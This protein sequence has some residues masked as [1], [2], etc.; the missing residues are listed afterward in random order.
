[1]QQYQ[2][3]R[4]FID[5]FIAHIDEQRESELQSILLKLFPADIAEL[6]NEL[7]TAQA[8]YVMHIL[9]SVKKVEVLAELEPDVRKDLLRGF[10][11]FEI[12]RE[13]IE[14]M[15]SDDAADILSEFSATEVNE[16]I[17]HIQDKEYSLNLSSLLKYPEDSA[18]GLMARELI[19]V[20]QNWTVAQCT[21]EIRKQAEEV[22]K[23]YSVY[24]VDDSDTLVGI[25]SLKKIIL[26]KAQ[27][28]VAQIS[29]TQIIS[30]NIYTKGDEVARLMKKYDL[31]AMPIT[32]T[33]NRLVGRV[34]ID[35]VVDLIQEEA[36]RDYQLLSGI[37]ENV[38][39]DDTI[40]LL[41]RARLPWLVIGLMGGIANAVVIGS[42]GDILQRNVQLAFFMPLVA[43]MGGNAGVQS[44]AIIVQSIANESIGSDSISKR[45]GKEFF[46]ATFNALICSALL[47]GIS[48]FMGQKTDI[49]LVVGISLFASLVFASVMGATIPLLLD[50]LKID[51][52][53]ATGPFITT[54]ND[55][56]GM[57]IYFLTGN[58]LLN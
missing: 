26:S 54:S 47:F 41:S 6:F 37:S 33:L 23:V 42:Y 52:A 58:M 40:W 28:K 19:K 24:V 20:N 55:L 35:D 48:F 22:T 15:D 39:S 27:T 34:T 45:L 38:E 2:I 51:P 3:T 14:N 11:P 46:V 4:E 21:E 5:E 29:D 32:D 13:F 31:E 7:N 1:M 12:A 44:S 49:T 30:A 25:V 18:G 53:L 57:F 17:G 56:L 36:E 10:E 50:R 43:A 16:I 9:D 8:V